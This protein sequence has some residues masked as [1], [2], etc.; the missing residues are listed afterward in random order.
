M[1]TIKLQVAD[2][3]YSH[4]MFL[5]SNLNIKELKILEDTTSFKDDEFY[6]T[7]AFTEHSANLVEEWKDS[8]EDEV[9]R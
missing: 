4:I 5:L 1:H 2:S 7:R 6:E 3:I 9:W 8:S